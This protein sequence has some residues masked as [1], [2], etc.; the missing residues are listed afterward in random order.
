MGVKKV[1]IVHSCITGHPYRP[2]S[3][4]KECKTCGGKGHRA[5][6]CKAGLKGEEKAKV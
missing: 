6:E 3:V 4:H 2:L 1:Q 5:A